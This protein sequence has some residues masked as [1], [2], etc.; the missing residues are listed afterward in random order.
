MQDFVYNY[1]GKD[2]PVHIIH[3]RI[4][5]IHY[6]FVDDGFVISCHS[7]TPKYIVLQGLNKYAETLIKRSIKV[8]PIDANYI[9]LYGVKV[10]LQES[11]KISF[12][13]GEEISYK[14]HKDLLKKL[15]TKFLKI[16]TNRTNYY[17]NL[18]HLPNYSVKIRNMKSRYGSNFKQKKEIHYS[19]ILQ[20]YSFEIIDS[21]I[22]HELSHE[23]VQNHSKEFYNVV[24]KYC[25]NYKALRK[26]LNK[27]EYK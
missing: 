16:V 22:I 26:K 15:N 25:P 9:Y 17:A 6:R 7:L 2:Y 19:T 18:M 14:D 10:P 21:V 3:K 27:G 13:D 4:K 8:K 5:N 23:L 1:N 11:G 12:T 20:H 24:Y